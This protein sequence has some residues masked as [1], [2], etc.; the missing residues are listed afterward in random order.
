MLKNIDI[1]EIDFS[2]LYE[3]NCLANSEGNIYHD[4]KY[5]YKIYTKM[6]SY[7]IKRKE[8]KINMLDGYD[9]ENVILPKGKLKLNSKFKGIYSDYIKNSHSL[10]DF[11]K[12]NNK[13][14]DYL[15]IINECTTTLKNIHENEIVVLDLS[16]DN[17]I[18]DKNYKHYFIDFE[19]CSLNNVVGD[20]IPLLTQ[21]YIKYRQCD[22]EVDYNFDRLSMLLC[23]IFSIFYKEIF[24]IDEYE[25]DKLSEKIKTLK[26]MKK[27]FVELKKRYKDLP[28]IPYMDE[29]IEKDEQYT[30]TRY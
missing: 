4:K 10:Y 21:D 7:I 14:S 17:I 5:F 18:F 16:F 28:Y 3:I 15:K 27:I 22:Y 6:P 2:K 9:I 20:K 8:L 29:L 24:E 11:K 25:Y 30:F 12:Q 19:S 26:N 1:K 23:F 13:L